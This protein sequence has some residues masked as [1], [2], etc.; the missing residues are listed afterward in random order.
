MQSARI[1]AM[2]LKRC[3][4]KFS[5]AFKFTEGDGIVVLV[6]E[7]KDLIVEANNERNK[8]RSVYLISRLLT[9]L[10]KIEERTN[11]ALDLNLMTIRQK[12]N[13]DMYIDAVRTSA[14][15]WRSYYDKVNNSNQSAAEDNTSEAES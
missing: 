10:D 14:R 1:L 4:A 2:Y 13:V 11:D 7:V 6:N 3:V 5:R 15:K 8:R 12:A 9:D